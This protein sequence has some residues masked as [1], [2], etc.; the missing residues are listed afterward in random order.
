MQYSSYNV[1]P[2]IILLF[3]YLN[4]R[5]IQHYSS[6]QITDVSIL[7]NGTII[8]ITD[9]VRRFRFNTRNLNTVFQSSDHR[10]NHIQKERSSI[11]VSMEGDFVLICESSIQQF[12]HQTTGIS[13][14]KRDL[15]SIRVT[16]WD[17]G[18]KRNL[19]TVSQLSDHRCIRI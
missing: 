10:C 8:N 6:Y 11:W 2:V 4:A 17:S 9:Y 7:K 19:N 15:I 5:N 16:I 18:L 12:S 1:I 3:Q 13:I 14:F